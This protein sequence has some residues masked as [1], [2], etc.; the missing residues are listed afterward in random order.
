METSALTPP[1]VRLRPFSALRALLRGLD[2]G[3]ATL[4]W[5]VA[6]ASAGG[7]A[8][9]GSAARR[10]VEAVI[11]GLITVVLADSRRLYRARTCSLRAVEV[12]RLGQV[13]LVQSAL[14][15]LVGPRLGLVVPARQILV[16]GV[17]TF[18][19]AAAA[20][21]IYRGWL[22]E[23]RRNGRFSRPVVILGSNEEALDLYRLATDHP[24]LGLAI[25][26]VIGDEV[27]VARLA[28]P[29]PYLGPLSNAEEIVHSSG[30]GGALIAATAVTSVE[31]NRISRSLL[32]GGIHV[33]LSNGLR[34]FAAHRLRLQSF[35]HEPVLYLEPAHLARWQVVAKRLVD[36]VVGSVALVLTAP[37]VALAAL[38]IKMEGGGPVIFR[39]TRVGRG[40]RPFTILKLRTM[41]H[42]AEARYGALA[43]AL[44]SRTGPLVKL[45]HDPRIT[46]VGRF[47]R[48][49]SIDE[50]PQ[51]VNVLRGSMSLVGPRPNLLVEAEGLDP[52]FLA[53]KTKMLPGITGLWQ[54]EAR[55][56]PSF[57]VYRRLDLFYLENWSI[58]L[59]LAI[60][61]ATAQRVCARSFRALRDTWRPGASPLSSD[62]TGQLELA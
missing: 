55:D 10:T 29:V 9:P 42:D 19:V 31:L 54:A 49:T 17:L 12:Q 33:H 30:A 28:F 14:V 4:G 39:Q 38:A 44:A 34:G 50:L 51:L 40:R 6:L 48:A 21:G 27:E 26:G 61:L 36:L 41:V 32:H 37:I 62:G 53:H 58:S 35:A 15:F 56:H 52:L 45:H 23:G 47:L 18:V 13:A 57:E 11:L 22:T 1:E 8:M 2:F 7:T 3:A 60:L 43:P 20:R 46:R 59:D 16:G 25:V 5:T 24:E